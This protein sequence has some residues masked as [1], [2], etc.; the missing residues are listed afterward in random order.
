MKLGAKGSGGRRYQLAAVLLTYA[1]VSLAAVPI[2]ISY[3]MKNPQRRVQAPQSSSQ[4]Q[5]S[6]PGQSSPTPVATDGTAPSAIT[7][8]SLLSALGSLVVLGLASPFLDLQ[9]DFTQGAIGLVILFVGIRFAWQLT[10]G[11]ETPPVVGPFA[12]R[13]APT[14]P[15]TPL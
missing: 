5:S 4:S 8:P 13:A 15:P 14:P 3:D 1:A 2:A 6:V 11:T 7:A 9:Q 12:N 10:A